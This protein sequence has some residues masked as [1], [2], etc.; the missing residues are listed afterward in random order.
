M[1]PTI[2]E[3]N[4]FVV[5]LIGTLFA[6]APCSYLYVQGTGLWLA[7]APCS[8]LYVEGARLWLG[9][10][11]TSHDRHRF[12][13]EVKLVIVLVETVQQIFETLIIWLTAVQ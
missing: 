8:Y 1:V 6:A 13:L 9:E 2:V 10:K 12:R 11:R 3:S 5:M 4:A 7:A